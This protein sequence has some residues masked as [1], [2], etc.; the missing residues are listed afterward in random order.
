MPKT[1]NLNIRIEPALKQKLVKLAKQ[2]KRSLNS[3]CEILFENHIADRQKRG[4]KK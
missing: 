1:E 3:Y 2:D 4:E